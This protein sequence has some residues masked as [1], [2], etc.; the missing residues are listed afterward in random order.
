MYM[1]RC[2]NICI[3]IDGCYV[4]SLALRIRWYAMIRSWLLGSIGPYWPKMDG[5]SFLS[6]QFSGNERGLFE[7]RCSIST[8][9]GKTEFLL[10]KFFAIA[11]LVCRRMRWM[12]GIARTLLLLRCESSWM[13]E[14]QKKRWCAV[15]HNVDYVEVFEVF[16]GKVIEHWTSCTT[17]PT[18]KLVAGQCIQ[19]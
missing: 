2:I 4:D 9:L 3:C 8:G 7:N 14:Q 12:G 13:L 6:H 18:I 17:H 19:D 10:Y 5:V 11:K 15:L 1:Y 16:L